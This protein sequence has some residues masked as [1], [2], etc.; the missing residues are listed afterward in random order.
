MASAHLNHLRGQNPQADLPHLMHRHSP[1]LQIVS[2]ALRIT[3]QVQRLREC[4]FGGET[5]GFK[6]FNASSQGFSM[7]YE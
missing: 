4:L 5:L 3:L 7:L 2:L 6:A 1:S